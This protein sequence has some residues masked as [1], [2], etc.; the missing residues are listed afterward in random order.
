V[1]EKQKDHCVVR[2]W[3]I[4]NWFD[5]GTLDGPVTPGK[6]N[7]EVNFK[8]QGNSSVGHVSG[9]RRSGDFWLDG[10]SHGKVSNHF[11][12]LL[13][14]K[15][16]HQRCLMRQAVTNFFGT[17]KISELWG[18]VLLTTPTLSTEP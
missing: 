5:I 6:V 11:L 14:K 1:L 17:S 10:V 13:F 18:M 2:W 8:Y 12:G 4:P 3:N 7:Y 15:L 16:T 9:N